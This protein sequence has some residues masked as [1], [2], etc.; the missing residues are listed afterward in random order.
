M[1]RPL[2]LLIIAVSVLVGKG[3][4]ADPASVEVSKLPIGKLAYVTSES[5]GSEGTIKVFGHS[6]PSFR[7]SNPEF[8]T[9]GRQ[10]VYSNL[11]GS[12]AS[13]F[14]SDLDSR[15]SLP[16]DNLAMEAEE[17]SLS[18]DGSRLLFVVWTAGRKSSHIYIS[19]SDGSRWLPL[20]T[21]DFY[22]WSPRWSPDGE[23]VLFESTR[24]GERQIYVMNPDGT[25]LVN[26]SNNK[27]LCHAPSWS[28][29][30]SHIAYMSRGEN[31]KANIF[32]MKSDG[33]EKANVSKGTTRDSE[34]VWSP[35]GKWIAFT[36]TVAS[37][38]AEEI[39]AGFLYGEEV[40]L[41]RKQ[42]TEA[43]RLLSEQCPSLAKLV[44][45]WCSHVVAVVARSHHHMEIF[46]GRRF[47]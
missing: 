25:N 6:I 8:T 16:V 4:A 37:P 15:S 5:F 36:R 41:W 45:E 7:G 3:L 2:T 40:S 13:L 31:G 44:D 9:S 22:D 34:P 1:I 38:P 21:G 39:Y 20:T 26:L 27:D 23:K 30:G 19:N 17:P 43:G 35:D 32:I 28:P 24:D 47:F 11:N 46:L 42:L 12:G 33:T 14:I 29:D 10:L 18:P